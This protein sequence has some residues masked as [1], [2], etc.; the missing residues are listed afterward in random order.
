VG[1][2]E[3][4][5]AAFTGKIYADPTKSASSATAFSAGINWYLNKNIRANLSYSHTEFDGYT[6]SAAAVGKQSENVLFTRVQLAF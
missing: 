6:G 4:D 1:K 2:L 5:D 3:V